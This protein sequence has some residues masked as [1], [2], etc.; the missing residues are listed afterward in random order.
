MKDDIGKPVSVIVLGLLMIAVSAGVLA[1]TTQHPIGGY[2]IVGTGGFVFGPFMVVTGLLGLTKGL[3]LRAPVS[4][5]GLDKQD[6]AQAPRLAAMQ[7]GAEV[8]VA[9]SKPQAAEPHAYN[10]SDATGLCAVFGKGHQHEG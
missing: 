4:Q 8:T 6:R 9:A 3:M 2:S 7:V 1:L 5:S 10:G